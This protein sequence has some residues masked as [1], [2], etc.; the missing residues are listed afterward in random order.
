MSETQAATAVKFAGEQKSEETPKP[1][2]AA[3]AAVAPANHNQDAGTDRYSDEAFR[4]A[5]DK[6][7]E[8][9]LHGERFE[10][11]EERRIAE[12]RREAEWKR[13]TNE[14]ARQR[15]RQELESSSGT[16]TTVQRRF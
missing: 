9:T 5:V 6:E 10:E 15:H 14:A 16:A 12:H 13:R 11:E 3:T 4:R 2:A 8:K 1:Q 7:Y